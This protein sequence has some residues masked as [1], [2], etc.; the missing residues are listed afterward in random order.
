MMGI[1]PMFSRQPPNRLE[2]LEPRLLFAVRTADFNN[3]PNTLTQFDWM[4]Q[5]AHTPS[6]GFSYTLGTG[7]GQRPNINGITWADASYFDTALGAGGFS[8]VNTWNMK[9]LVL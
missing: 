4:L 7:D 6:S 5:S 3:Y 1:A 2:P 9:P 8:T